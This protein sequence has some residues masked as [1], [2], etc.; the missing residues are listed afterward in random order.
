VLSTTLLASGNASDE[1]R[2]WLD[3]VIAVRTQWDIAE[4]PL[5]YA[6][7]P[8]AHWHVLR[9]EHEE[10]ARLLDQVEAVGS[11]VEPELHARAATT[12]AMIL[13]ARGDASG[14]LRLDQSAYEITSRDRGA[15][16]PRAARY[17]LIYARSLR[18]AGEITQAEA[19]EREYRPR[20]EAAYPPTSAF[21]DLLLPL[22]GAPASP[23]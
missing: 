16:H 15:G 5:A 19:L 1:V 13:R 8:L 12:R 7:L 23:P 6:R 3:S 17:A 20:L 14:A 2:A 21:R 22:T 4:G 10:A 9:G 18:A 11:L